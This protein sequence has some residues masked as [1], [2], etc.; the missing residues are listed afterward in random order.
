M[1]SA[2]GNAVCCADASTE[3]VFWKKTLHEG[4]PAE[5][6]LDHALTPPAIVNGK[7][8]LGTIYGEVFCLAALTGEVTWKA[9]IGE[10]VMFQPAV[11]RGRVYVGTGSGSLFALETGDPDDDGWLMWGAGPTHN[12]VPEASTV[13]TGGSATRSPS[14]A[15]AHP[16]VPEAPT[17]EVPKVA[18]RWRWWKR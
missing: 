8:F 9:N 3:E 4:T 12:G 7:L 18:S 5:E 14:A 17:V 11:A 6:L 10:P 15:P 13:T 1:Y 16:S 2:L